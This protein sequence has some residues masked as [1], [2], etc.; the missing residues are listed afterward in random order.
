MLNNPKTLIVWCNK[1]SNINCSDDGKLKVK[2]CVVTVPD[3]FDGMKQ[4]F[5]ERNGTY[6]DNYKDVCK[7][8]PIL[9]PN[10]VDAKMLANPAFHLLVIKIV[11]LSRFCQT[12]LTHLDSIHD[13]AV[14]SAMIET[15]IQNGE[16]YE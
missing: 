10:G 13:D 7:I 3:I 4:T 14:Y 16:K 15:V 6:R 11:K 9:F 2:H 1:M 8:L 12:N 5:I